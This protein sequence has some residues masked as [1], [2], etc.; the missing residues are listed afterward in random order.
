[1]T[2]QTFLRELA[3][4]SIAIAITLPIFF[5]INKHFDD[6]RLLER[7]VRSLDRIEAAL[8]QPYFSKMSYSKKDQFYP[9]KLI[10]KL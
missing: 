2:I 6:K 9:K 8:T 1:M 5:S 4:L 10:K 7:Q 3:A